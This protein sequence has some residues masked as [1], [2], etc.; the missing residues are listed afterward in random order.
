M[1][2]KRTPVT[3][4]IE[5]TNSMLLKHRKGILNLWR[6]YFYQLLNPV[7]VQHLETSEKK[8][9]EELHLTEAEVRTAIKS[10]KAGKAPGE[11][12]IRPE[13]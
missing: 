10:S 12:D 5:D 8:I 6:E 13:I 2:G 9:D 1:R 3:T 11:D 7:T 4:F